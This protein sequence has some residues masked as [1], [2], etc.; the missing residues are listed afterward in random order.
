MNL[1]AESSAVLAWLLTEKEGSR[2]QQLLSGA[3]LA[4]SS[5]LTLV[6]CDRAIIRLAALGRISETEAVDLRRELAF[7]ASRWQ[8]FR[9]GPEIA[10]RARRSFPV[11][12]VRSLDAIHLA[13]ALAAGSVVPNLEILSLDQRIRN[14]A[15]ELGFRLQPR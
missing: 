4:T 7:A 13:T 1:Y 10:E 8:M 3:E 9:I 2:V 14:S 11:E 5:D 6:E 15:R 12:P